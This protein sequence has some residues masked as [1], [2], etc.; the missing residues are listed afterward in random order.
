[1][2]AKRSLKKVSNQDDK[3]IGV[4]P[5][6]NNGKVNQEIK[7]LFKKY[8]KSTHMGGKQ[9]AILKRSTIV[10]GNGSYKN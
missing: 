4:L 10:A 5:V 2:R 3:G 1:M 9:Q 8:G 6:K 7:G